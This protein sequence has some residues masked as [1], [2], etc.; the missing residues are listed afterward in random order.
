MI[1]F[2]V[3]GPSGQALRIRPFDQQWTWT[4][5]AQFGTPMTIDEAHALKAA[6]LTGNLDEA[7]RVES[8]RIVPDYANRT[9]ETFQTP[10]HEYAEVERRR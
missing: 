1:S 8:A 2:V 9:P 3:L 5:L 7:E 4:N 6:V 10:Q